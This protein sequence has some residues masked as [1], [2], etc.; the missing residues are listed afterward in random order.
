MSL[1][2]GPVRRGRWLALLFVPAAVVFSGC[3]LGDYEKRED[4]ERIRVAYFDNES[5]AVIEPINLPR[6]KIPV[7]ITNK[8]GKK[9]TKLEPN[10]VVKLDVFLRPPKGYS[11]RILKDDDATPYN[12]ILYRYAAPR[13]SAYNLFI[14]A[15]NDKKKTLEDFHK[16][17][18]NALVDFYKQEYKRPVKF[19]AKPT[20]T[21]QRQPL[22]TR[23]NPPPA[24]NFQKVTY[25]DDLKEGGQEFHVFFY[26]AGADQV[27]LVFQMPAGE[28]PRLQ[29]VLDYSLKT[30]D[31]RTGAA[32][33][34]RAYQSRPG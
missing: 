32:S 2:I 14:A 29:D 8:Q 5:R 34:R 15:A 31:I 1:P 3:D 7:G 19:A 13:N 25:S 22:K 21:D 11:S 33:K 18:R 23:Y 10:P 20:K 4:E 17:V 9:D 26:K 16:E 30:F 28:A 24:T 12:N 6:R 27:A